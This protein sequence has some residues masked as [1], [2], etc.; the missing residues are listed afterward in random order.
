M[1]REGLRRRKDP[2]G[3]RGFAGGKGACWHLGAG[4][5][6]V[7]DLGYGLPQGRTPSGL[8]IL[9]LGRTGRN[10]SIRCFI[11]TDE[12]TEVQNGYITCT[13]SESQISKVLAKSKDLTT[14]RRR[15]EVART[16]GFASLLYH[17]RLWTCYPS[18]AQYLNCTVGMVII[19]IIVIST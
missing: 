16:L 1:C 7:G 10:V 12:E 14:S 13:K 4:A 2:S 6:R 3:S 17:L 9:K 15:F 19:L 18:K 8:I 11:F 5:E